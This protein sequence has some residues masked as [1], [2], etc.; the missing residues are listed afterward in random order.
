M[1]SVEGA[2]LK[3]NLLP[4]LPNSTLRLVIIC[5]QVAFYFIFLSFLEGITLA[6]TSYIKETKSVSRPFSKGRD[7]SV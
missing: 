5:M 6:I 3:L 2:P 4:L 7:L 1:A